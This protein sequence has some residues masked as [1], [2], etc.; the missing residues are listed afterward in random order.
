[1]TD[2]AEGTPLVSVPLVAR[3]GEERALV[4]HGDGRWSLCVYR[5]AV[6]DSAKGKPHVTA[7]TTFTMDDLGAIAMQAFE[8]NPDIQQNKHAGRQLAAGVLL[9]MMGLGL[10]A[11]EEKPAA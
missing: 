3:P 4:E 5:R 1:M 9:M 10:I 11:R 8:S 2:S 7:E 6:V